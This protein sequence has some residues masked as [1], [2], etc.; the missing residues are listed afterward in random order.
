VGSTSWLPFTLRWYYLVVLANLGLILGSLIV[1]LSCQSRK[2]HGLG[3]NDGSSMILFGWRFTPTLIA[4][5]YAQMT[6]ILFEDVKR[7]GPISVRFKEAVHGVLM[8]I[9]SWLLHSCVALTRAYTCVEVT[10]GGTTLPPIGSTL[11]RVVGKKVVASVQAM[12]PL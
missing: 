12:P 4:V 5:L 2:N 11:P 7:T 3:D 8:R 10:L 1:W 6:V 9:I